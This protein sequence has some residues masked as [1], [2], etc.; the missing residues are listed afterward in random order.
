VNEAL[1]QDESA[2]SAKAVVPEDVVAALVRVLPPVTYADPEVLVISFV[3]LYAVVVASSVAE[4][5][6]KAI[7]KVSAVV[8]ARTTVVPIAWIPFK[9]CSL[10]E[11]VI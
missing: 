3:V 4:D 2:K 9:S 1:V 8:A 6:Y 7:L 10:N 5:V 11:V